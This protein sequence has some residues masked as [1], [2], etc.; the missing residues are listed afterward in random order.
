[1]TNVEGC[2]ESELEIGMALL[3]DF[4]VETDEVTVPIFR[5]A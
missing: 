5:P 2:D 3:V 4:R 1:M